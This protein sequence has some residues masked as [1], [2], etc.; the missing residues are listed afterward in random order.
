MMK[1]LTGRDSIRAVAD[2]FNIHRGAWTTKEV[3][4]ELQALDKEIATA[5]D[6]AAIIGT[7]AWT[8]IIC[9]ECGNIVD[10]AMQF[11]EYDHDSTPEVVCLDCLKAAIDL[12]ESRK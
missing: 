1:V 11:G 4:E 12:L 8:D 6:V 7:R 10:S 9:S 3:I 5:D 2:E